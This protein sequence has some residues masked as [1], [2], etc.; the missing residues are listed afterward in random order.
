MELQLKPDAEQ[1]FL[2]LESWWNGDALDR[3]C[4]AITAPR[5]GHPVRRV[6]HP[7]SLEERW[8]NV[9]YVVESTV[10]R[11][12]ATA[13]LGEAIPHAF[14]NLG[15]NFLTATLGCPLRFLPSTTWTDAMIADWS[16]FQGFADYRES[17]WY[18]L[19]IEM[20]AR[21]VEVGAGRF[22]TAI[23]DLH[24]G[25]DGVASL[26]GSEDFMRDL[27]D[28]PARVRETLDSLDGFFCELVDSL[29]AITTSRGQEGNLGFLTWGPG[30]VCPVQDDSLALLSPRAVEEFLLESILRQAR[31]VDHC[32]FHL[33]GPQCLDKLDMLLACREIR[34]IQWQPG[35]GHRPMRKW[36][37]L[38]RKIL[39]RGKLLFI[40]CEPDELAPILSAV[41]RKG[42]YIATH[43]ADEEQAQRMLETA[44]RFGR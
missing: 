2:R 43:A 15:P 44:K 21:F 24:P 38:M 23:T 8:T 5:S 37:D 33:D 19:M 7:G 6:A 40:D 36:T 26:R 3:P 32:M 16:D 25:G 17:R 20:T 39:T 12:E 34:G 35:A 9:D 4:L 29:Y 14:P 13:F 31:H 11:L 18:R 27:F 22:L 1:A 41:P 10:A 30:K 28:E 42:L